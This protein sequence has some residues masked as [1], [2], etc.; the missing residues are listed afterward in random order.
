MR[1]K[2]SLSRVGLWLVAGLSVCALLAP[3]A[4]QAKSWG[5]SVSGYNYNALPIDRFKVESEAGTAYGSSMPGLAYNGGEF[6][7]STCCYRIGGDTLKVSYQ[8]WTAPKNWKQGDPE[9]PFVTRTIPFPRASDPKA[10]VLEIYFLPDGSVDSRLVSVRD[11][12]P[13]P[14]SRVIERIRKEH[15]DLIPNYPDVTNHDLFR[16]RLSQAIIRGWLLGLR[17]E[18]D[19]YGFS[20]R[21]V[22]INAGFADDPSIAPGL[23]ARKGNPPAIMN[24]LTHDVS[25]ATWQRLAAEQ[26]HYDETETRA[27]DEREKRR[28]AACKNIF[29]PCNFDE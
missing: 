4:A 7:T 23:D 14:Y 1:L 28:N 9:P 27:Q 8:L 5:V 15:P 11:R 6:A 10:R 25:A 20:M 29:K 18:D 22:T 16:E 3:L 21:A 13:I 12:G 2:H 17:S 24:Y 26:K 19:L